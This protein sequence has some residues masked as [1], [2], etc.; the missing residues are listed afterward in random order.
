VLGVFGLLFGIV[1]L[2]VRIGLLS[3]GFSPD[4]G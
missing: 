2:L 1:A 4:L 3:A